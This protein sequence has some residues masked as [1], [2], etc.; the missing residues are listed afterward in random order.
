MGHGDLGNVR[1]FPK[2]SRSREYLTSSWE[3]KEI[4]AWLRTLVGFLSPVNRYCSCT[5][6][7]DQRPCYHPTTIIIS[8]EAGEAQR[9][10]HCAHQ[11]F[12]PFSRLCSGCN[13]KSGIHPRRGSDCRANNKIIHGGYHISRV[14]GR[15]KTYNNKGKKKKKKKKRISNSKRILPG[16]LIMTRASFLCQVRYLC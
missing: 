6:C 8:C 4:K 14:G 3:R 11:T 2:G 5:L 12:W 10:G 7:R 16:L 1:L 15:R 13:K 9:S